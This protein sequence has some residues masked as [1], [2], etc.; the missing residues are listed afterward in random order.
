MRQQ[1]LFVLYSTL[2][3][4]YYPPTIKQ[5]REKLE[6]S[7]DSTKT[8]QDV[9]ELVE[10]HG[11]HG[12]VDALISKSGPTVQLQLEDMADTLEIL[13]K[14]VYPFATLHRWPPFGMP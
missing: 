13:K 1:I 11:P 8:A 5:L 6:R 10:Q 9:H 3:S 4:R 7:E 12:W 14:C 2:K